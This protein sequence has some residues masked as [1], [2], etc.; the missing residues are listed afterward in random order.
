MVQ[1]VLWYYE[2]TDADAAVALFADLARFIVQCTI[3]TTGSVLILGLN[4]KPAFS[5]NTV[6]SVQKT[7][8][9]LLYQI[10]ILE[11]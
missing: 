8:L 2:Y 5:H 11:K 3:Q 6:F 1:K 4:A 7:M 9:V 10:P